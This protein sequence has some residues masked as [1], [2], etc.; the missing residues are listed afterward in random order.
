[1]PTMPARPM[2]RMIRQTITSISVK[3]PWPRRCATVLISLRPD[4]EHA[5]G[6]R[7][8]GELGGLGGGVVA[9]AVVDGLL[10]AAVGGVHHAARYVDR[11]GALDQHRGR[12]RGP[13][14]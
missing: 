8:L 5:E 7:H 11:G 10:R 13:T 12:R 14:G 2:P 6:L 1:M 3:P 4:P 9:R